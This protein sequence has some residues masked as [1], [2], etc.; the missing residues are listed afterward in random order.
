[1]GGTVGDGS[2]GGFGAVE[3]VSKL[4]GLAGSLLTSCLGPDGTGLAE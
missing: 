3:I 2:W 4:S 1:M